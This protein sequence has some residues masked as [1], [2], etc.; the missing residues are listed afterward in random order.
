MKLVLSILLVAACATD[1]GTPSA[2]DAA[3]PADGDPP[4]TADAPSADG[5]LPG[6][7]R[8]VFVRAGVGQG[9]FPAGDVYVIRPDGSDE[10]QL[11]TTGDAVFATWAYD[12]QRIAFT[13]LAAS[14]EPDIWIMGAD[15]SEPVQLTRQGGLMPSWAPDGTR[16]AYMA[17]L[18]GAEIGLYT[19]APRADAT[20]TLLR[21]DAFFASFSPD[22]T[23]IVYTGKVLG[24]DRLHNEI[25]VM[26]ADGQNPR[27]LTFADDDPDYPDANASSWSPDGA[28]I[29]FFCGHEGDLPPAELDP[30]YHQGK[31]QVC[32]IDADGG[33]R[34]VLT[35]CTE[36]GS[37]NPGWSPDGRVYFDRGSFTA[38]LATR[39]IDA[40]GANEAP[41]FDESLGAGRL[42]WR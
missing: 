9:P 33:D 41:L 27:Q 14:G 36:C 28:T 2:S 37:D 21:A 32:L 10:Q 13:R 20:P 38:P 35:A 40:D 4:I 39:I 25:F 24:A 31:Q 30:Y 6:D 7:E 29:A 22:G 23:R 11:T 34:R 5:G 1:P 16:I 8:V 17:P 3:T 18:E 12:R 26:D 19:I 42:M 15:G